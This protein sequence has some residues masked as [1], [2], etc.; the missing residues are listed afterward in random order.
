MNNHLDQSPE[1][2]P[3]NRFL[4]LFKS[5]PVLKYFMRFVKLTILLGILW[6]LP[7]TLPDLSLL[8]HERQ[9]SHTSN[10]SLN[11]VEN[12]N[13]SMR[14]FIFPAYS[15]SVC[16]ILLTSVFVFKF[17]REETVRIKQVELEKITGKEEK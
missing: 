4:T 9:V 7:P 11:S 15:I 13:A 17:V 8:W 14:P 5:D 1:I 12:H 10:Q 3:E 2:N 16:I 6:S